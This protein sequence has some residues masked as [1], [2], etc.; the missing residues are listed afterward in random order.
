M[1]K[2]YIYCLAQS[3]IKKANIPGLNFSGLV[4]SINYRDI[5]AYVSK[6]TDKKIDREEIKKRLEKD[7]NWAKA[8]IVMHHRV[9]AQAG[10]NGTIIPM[11]FGTIISSKSD[12]L[13]L[14]KD[15][16]SNFKKLLSNLEGRQEWGIKIYFESD[17]LTDSFVNE[18]S[19]NK[20]SNQTWHEETKKNEI[21]EERMEKE[22]EKQLVNAIEILRDNSENLVLNIPLPQKMDRHKGEMLINSSV[23]VKEKSLSNFSKKIMKLKKD[24][25]PFGL[26]TEI[27]GPWPPYN[28]VKIDR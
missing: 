14:M 16:Y 6:I 10:K 22:I 12:L 21:K 18:V 1:S 4:F 2:I 20:N 28:F 19:D 23:L 3:P 24:L 26:D 8:N 17:R 13:R 11:K 5:Y 27:T 15:Y 7:S 25:E 9:I